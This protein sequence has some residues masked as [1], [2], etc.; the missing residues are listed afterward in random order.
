MNDYGAAYGAVNHTGNAHKQSG[1]VW[2][3]SGYAGGDCKNCHDVHGTAN[4]RDEVRGEFGHEE[5]SN[6]FNCHGGD[7]P[8]DTD[9]QQYYPMAAGG[10]SAAARAGHKT[11][12]AGNLPAGS[13]LPCYDCHNPHGNGSRSAYGLMVIASINSSIVVLGDATGEIDM[14]PGRTDAQVR[15]YCFSCHTTSDSGKGWN[16]TGYTAVTSAD[17]FEGIRRDTTVSGQRLRLVPLAAHVEADGTSCYLCHGNGYGATGSNVHKP[18]GG[19]SAG[20]I[21]C[22][23]CHSA[24]KE[25]MDAA[26]T[27][28]T[29]TYHHVLGTGS[30]TGDNT[31]AAGSYPT[32]TTNVYCLSCHTDHDLFNDDKGANLRTN[33]AASPVATNTDFVA[34]GSYGICVSC[35]SV[36]EPKDKTNQKSGGSTVTPVISGADYDPA[37][38]D[39]EATSTFAGPSDHRANCSKCHSDEQARSYQPSTYGFG[40]HYSAEKRILAALGLSVPASGQTEEAACYKC[41]STT[42]NP[43]QASNLDYYGVKSMDATSLSLESIFSST[44]KH[45]V[46]SSTASGRHT[47]DESG[48]AAFGSANRHVECEDC[49][50]VHAAQAGG[51]APVA[52]TSTAGAVLRGATAVQPTYNAVNWGAVTGWTWTTITA[53]GYESNVCFKCHSGYTTLP[54]P[55]SGSSATSMTDVAREFNPYNQSGHNVQVADIATSW[56]KSR[57]FVS[58]TW[59]TWTTQRRCSSTWLLGTWRL[60]ASTA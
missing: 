59:Y 52:A 42:N 41:H 47:T 43:N 37:S 56:P 11:V 55:P 23:L 7:G 45:Y 39:Y 25:T 13:A 2:P 29:N 5:F 28:K 34:S 60:P 21:R 10:E 18:T 36:Q 46:T 15:E 9:I 50:N 14:S 48:S 12:S 31:Y 57:F 58:G 4:D 33:L 16:G 26:G 19:E 8:G 30:Y 20:G 40:T 38:H 22:Y 49:H 51:H 44:Y 32:S 27:Q 17:M 3:G 54:A 24:Y 35:H 6:C 1:V 53:T